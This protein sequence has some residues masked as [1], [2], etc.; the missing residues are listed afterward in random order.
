MDY[1]IRRRASELDSTG[2]MEVGPGRYD[3]RHWQDGF[4]FVWEDAFGMAEG[5]LARYLPEY[6]HFG[7]NDVPR[8]VGL[9]VA[10]EW[11]RVAEALPS[12]TADEASDA[13]HLVATF[14]TRMDD[15]VYEHR[16][17]VA[18]LLLELADAFERFYAL[19]DWVCVLGM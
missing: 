2:Y 6:D 18:D 13:L 14:S 12:M 4:L 10:A 9:A 15:E 5:I 7:M 11:R 19:E 17:E 3:G 16:G 1:V 8:S